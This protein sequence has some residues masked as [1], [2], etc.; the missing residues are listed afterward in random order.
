MWSLNTLQVT[1]DEPDL[2]QNVN[3]VNPWL[4]ELISNIPAMNISSYSS[5]TKKLCF[6]T[7]PDFPRNGQ[8][9]MSS[10]SGNT[11]CPRSSLSYVTNNTSSSGIQGA[12]QASSDIHFNKSRLCPSLFS[13]I[14]SSN[15]ISNENVSCTFSIGSSSNHNNGEPKKSKKQ[16]LVLFGK[17]ILTEQEIS[18]KLVDPS[19]EQNKVCYVYIEGENLGK[20][21]DLSM[22]HSYK[23]LYLKL[24]EMFQ[25]DE[26]YTFNH[27]LYRDAAGTIKRIGNEPFRYVKKSC[28]SH[29]FLVKFS[30]IQTYKLLVVCV[31]KVTSRTWRRS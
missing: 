19:R 14:T 10:L 21:L 24:S 17:A 1:W 7:H 12:R 3:R 27:V 22:V 11:L 6:S 16:H 5:P 20:S 28:L 15:T 25:I 8:I 13:S 4:V 9:S 2:L 29:I 26:A 31:V 18:M 30:C 23:E